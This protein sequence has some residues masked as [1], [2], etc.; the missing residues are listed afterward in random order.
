MNQLT[1]RVQFLR[2]RI[3]L[4]DITSS[5]SSSTTES[6]IDPSSSSNNEL[7]SYNTNAPAL[8]PAVLGG[9]V[10][11]GY[12]VSEIGKITNNNQFNLNKRVDLITDRRDVV[13]RNPI[14]Y[15]KQRMKVQRRGGNGGNLNK[16]GGILT[17]PTMISDTK[18]VNIPKRRQRY[19][20][21]TTKKNK[22]GN[23]QLV[24]KNDRIKDKSRKFCLCR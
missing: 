7:I 22:N 16:G 21:Q 24:V 1:S 2:N 5:S 10:G 8:I 23:H 19:K 18:A 4:S 17:D 20:D 14:P 15:P 13:P 3:L 9:L 6:T 11:L 12:V